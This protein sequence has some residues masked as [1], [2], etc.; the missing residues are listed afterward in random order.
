M[1]FWC[2]YC[3]LWTYFTPFSNVSIVDFEQGNG[4]WV[5][6]IISGYCKS[7]KKVSLTIVGKFYNQANL[8]ELTNIYSPKI[9]RNP[10][11]KF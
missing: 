6:S 9:I 3:Q 7:D 5:T 1:T 10:I 8:S 11:A 2:F 4:S